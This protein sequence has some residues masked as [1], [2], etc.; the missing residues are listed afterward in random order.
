MKYLV[1]F[2]DNNSKILQNIDIDID[3]IPLKSRSSIQTCRNIFVF[4]SSLN[5]SSLIQSRVCIVFS[6]HN[7][8]INYYYIYI[9]ILFFLQEKNGLYRLCFKKIPYNEYNLQQIKI[10]L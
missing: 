8:T 10:N 3:S 1:K 5:C 6:M 4:I 7:I 2:K 9:Y